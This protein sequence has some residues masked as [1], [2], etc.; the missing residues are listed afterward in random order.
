MA[1][2]KTLLTYDTVID[3]EPD[4][5]ANASNTD[6]VDDA[7]STN[8]SITNNSTKQSAEKFIPNFIHVIQFCQLCSKGKITPVHY[9]IV[10]TDEVD[11]WFHYVLSSCNLDARRQLKR[12]I[13]L[14]TN[15]DDSDDDLISPNHKA[16]KMDRHLLNTILKSTIIWT[17]N[18]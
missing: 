1:F 7:T 4:S 10:S 11:K 15:H 2:L 5:Q 3:N 17:N 12:P 14:D 8:F 18:R 6:I 13:P 16:S 9:K